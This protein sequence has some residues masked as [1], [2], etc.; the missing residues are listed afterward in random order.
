M[1]WKNKNSISSPSKSKTS[2]NINWSG[3]INLEKMMNQDVK[4]KYWF[5]RCSEFVNW[6]AYFSQN[7]KYWIIKNNWE[8][9]ADWLDSVNFFTDW[10]FRFVRNKKHWWLKDDGKALAYWY[11]ACFDFSEW[12]WRFK[13]SDWIEWWIKSDWTILAEWFKYRDNFSCWDFQEWFASFWVDDI[14]NKRR[15]RLE[16]EVSSSFQNW[17]S[18]FK[19]KTSMWWIKRDATIL[20]KGFHMCFPFNEDFEWYAKFVKKRKNHSLTLTKIWY[21]DT[22]WREWDSVEN[23][24]WEL[25]VKKDEKFYIAKLLKTK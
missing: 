5:F 8:I 14:T 23:R 10:L 18:V 4:D 13:R 19:T 7:N 24:N 2:N 16:G 25:Y 6:F 21:I 1:F 17:Y 12:F 11:A 3:A 15:W 9:I 20:A 22:K